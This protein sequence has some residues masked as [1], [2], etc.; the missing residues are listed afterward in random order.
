M[1]EPESEIIERSSNI[2]KYIIDIKTHY[3]S[4][5]GGKIHSPKEIVIALTD[6]FTA[7][8]EA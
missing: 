5:R 3:Y 6:D 8:K 7:V 1:L 4:H 2:V